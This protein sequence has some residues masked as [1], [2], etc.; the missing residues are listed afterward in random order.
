MPVFAR[1]P[2]RE[3][4]EFLPA[5]LEV[6]ETPPSPVGIWLI[7]IICVLAVSGITWSSLGR[8]DVVAIAQ[9]KI[10]PTGRVKVIQ[11][12]ETGRAASVL[13]ENGMHVEI[14]DVLLEFESADADADV[15]QLQAEISS[16][17][18][19]AARRRT[20]IDLVADRQVD[21][22]PN[23]E[24]IDDVPLNISMR[25]R[26]V[27]EGDLKK[28]ASTVEGLEAQIKQKVREYERFTAT[29][30]A[31]SELLSTLQQR[32]DLRQSLRTSGSGSRVDLIE[33]LQA[34]Q[35]QKSTLVTAQGQIRESEAS[36]EVLRRGIEDAFR[37]FTAD[38]L[39]KIVDAERR[40]DE[41]AERLV[42]AKVRQRHMTLRSPV[43]GIVSALSVT[44]PGQVIT[45]G[46]EVMRI[47]PDGIGLEIE[48]YLANRDVGFVKLGQKAVIKVESLPFTR[49]G[50]IDATLTNIASDAIPQPDA[51][52][53]EGN[54]AQATSRQSMF[55]GVQRIQNLFYPALFEPATTHMLADGAMIRLSAGMA[56][57]V[58][59]KTGKRRI[60]EYLFS[61]L[62]EVANEA[63]KER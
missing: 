50:T 53:T 61:P 25:E 3:D 17:K 43:A 16:L 42:K 59:I 44:T 12:S 19:E 35:E 48:A 58:E 47:V 45:V 51:E 49:Y 52:S 31:V 46:E 36:A 18:A 21:V 7:W 20:A 28:L 60:I 13:V 1:R 23:M 10:Q 56:V 34:L 22:E 24:L 11:P 14:G 33:A 39:Q 41:S 8:I 55:A 27:L 62:L 63:M 15:D 5:A 6:L 38:N 57:T 4:Q 54:P 30:A 37:T 26:R 2:N 9:G 32:V 40:I 29:A